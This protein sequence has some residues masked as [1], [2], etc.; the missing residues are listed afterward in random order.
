M[1]GYFHLFSASTNENVENMWRK[2]KSLYGWINYNLR[3]Q[4]GHHKQTLPHLKG[5]FAPKMMIQSL[6]PC[7]KCWWE[8]CHQYDGENIKTYSSRSH[9]YCMTTTV[10]SEAKTKQKACRWAAWDHGSWNVLLAFHLVSLLLTLWI[11]SRSY[12]DR[13]MTQT[14]PVN[15]VRI[16]LGLN[17]IR[18]ILGYQC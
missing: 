11:S 18:N 16:S 10:M 3:P 15:K 5:K 14:V 9:D 1:S 8:L 13:R 7:P 6:Y 2:E 17:N 12:S 4:W